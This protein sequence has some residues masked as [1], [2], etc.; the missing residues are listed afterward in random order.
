M[1]K[2]IWK[3]AKSNAA[4]GNFR[5]YEAP[6]FLW[7]TSNFFRFFF[8]FVFSRKKNKKFITKQPRKHKSGPPKIHRINVKTSDLFSLLTKVYSQIV[9]QLKR[10]WWE[11][12]KLGPQVLPQAK[13]WNPGIT[14]NIKCLTKR[15]TL[16]WIHTPESLWNSDPIVSHS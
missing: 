14:Y 6:S 15:I 11:R 10:V 3:Q 16:H 12:E 9:L 13:L 8:I 2:Q 1:C 4:A 5:I 7:T